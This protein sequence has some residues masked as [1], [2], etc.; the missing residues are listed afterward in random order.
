MKSRAKHRPLALSGRG[1][2]NLR[3]KNAQSNEA[4]TVVTTINPLR[5]IDDLLNDDGNTR[6]RYFSLTGSTT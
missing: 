5:R 6:P 4:E 2:K 3:N 1:L